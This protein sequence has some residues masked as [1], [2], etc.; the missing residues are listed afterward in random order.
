ML[1]TASMHICLQ[2]LCKSVQ[3][4][5]VIET[6]QL[7]FSGAN[8]SVSVAIVCVSVIMPTRRSKSFNWI[9]SICFILKL[10]YFLLPLEKQLDLFL[11]LFGIYL[12]NRLPVGG[13]CVYVLQMFFVFFSFLFFVFCF[14]SVRQ[15][16]ETTVFRNGWTD[17][18]ETFTKW[19]RGKCS[20]KRRAAAWRKSCRRL[21][22]GECWWFA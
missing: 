1:S 14:F 9:C 8:V 19:Y 11:L 22:N 2:A 16:Y 4:G 10:N 12:R 15:K 5:D 6:M 7:L 20:L 18:H 21:A 3:F 13:G 17:F